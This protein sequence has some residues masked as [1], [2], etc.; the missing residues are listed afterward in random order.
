MIIALVSKKCYQR[1]GASFGPGQHPTIYDGDISGA[2]VI[3]PLA[4]Q[5]PPQLSRILQAPF[6]GDSPVEKGRVP[7]LRI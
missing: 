1:T 3:F 7:F 6:P 2:E 5:Q 4:R